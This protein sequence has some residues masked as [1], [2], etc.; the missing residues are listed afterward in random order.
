MN[1]LRHLVSGS[2]HVKFPVSFLRGSIPGIQSC[3]STFLAKPV[4]ETRRQLSISMALMGDRDRKMERNMRKLDFDQSGV[5]IQEEVIN[6]DSLAK[7]ESGE[8][9]E[10]EIS[11]FPDETT[12]EQIFNGIAFKDL[13]Y[14]TMV[15]HRNNTRLIAR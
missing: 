14:V 9:Q 1:S 4:M 11:E 8:E 5:A 13:P 10:Q 12:S 15:L 3:Q 2:H 6:L 7:V